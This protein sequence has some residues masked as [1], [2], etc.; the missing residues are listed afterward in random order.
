MPH[1]STK[2]IASN[3]IFHIAAGIKNQ[4][5]RQRSHQYYGQSHTHDQPNGCGGV[6]PLIHTVNGLPN[7]Q[8]NGDHQEIGE[9]QT[10][11]SER[12]LNPIWPCVVSE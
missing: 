3:R 5:P 4:N 2:Q 6:E 12:I 1:Q 7:L 10:Y 11:D 8:W 9:P